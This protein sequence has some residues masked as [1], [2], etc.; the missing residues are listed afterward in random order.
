MIYPFFGN[1]PG[2]KHLYR[3]GWIWRPCKRVDL[4]MM[5][6]QTLIQMIF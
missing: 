1:C 4:Q 2:R 6:N 5:Q 3:H